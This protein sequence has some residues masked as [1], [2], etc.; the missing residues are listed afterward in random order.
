M[1]LSK[2]DCRTLLKS[3]LASFCT[4]FLSLFTIPSHVAGLRGSNAISCGK[5][6]MVKV[7]NLVGRAKVCP[8]FEHEG[9]GVRRVTTFNQALLDK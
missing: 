4:Y 3:T 6:R 7:I 5:G 9:L 2:G 8:P 1:Y